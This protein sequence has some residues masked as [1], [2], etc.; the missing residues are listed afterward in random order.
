[1]ILG[2]REKLKPYTLNPKSWFLGR[3]NSKPQNLCSWVDVGVISPDQ[4]HVDELV[5]VSL[6][7]FGTHNL[8][9]YGLVLMSL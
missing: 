9:V 5:T 3:S 8:Q 4:D 7:R 2:R 6:Q 1:M